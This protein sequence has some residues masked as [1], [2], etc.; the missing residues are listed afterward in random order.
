MALA[1]LEQTTFQQRLC[2]D[3]AA[4]NGTAKFSEG[5]ERD[6]AN[7]TPGSES[8]QAR[9]GII[10]SPLQNTHAPESFHPRPSP[11][12]ALTERGFKG[13]MEVLA[14][15]KRLAGVGVVE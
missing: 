14:I 10:T 15:T 9:L 3:T 2:S 11:P 7:G 13:A 8:L 1:R 4:P 5:L 6:P 12:T